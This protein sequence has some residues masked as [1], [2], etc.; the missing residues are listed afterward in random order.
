[1][2]D[3]KDTPVEFDDEG[4]WP[5]WV[6]QWIRDLPHVS[7]DAQARRQGVEPLT[8]A[9]DLAVPGFFESD[10][11]MEELIADLY[12]SRARELHCLQHH[13]EIA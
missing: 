4:R 3:H 6:P 1:M 10:E 11:E 7:A 9:A 8:S 12:E 5:A 13:R 2:I